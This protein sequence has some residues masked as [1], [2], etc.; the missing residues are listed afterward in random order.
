MAAVIGGLFVL[1]N[2]TILW[3]IIGRSR[4]AER[5][6]EAVRNHL[7]WGLVLGAAAAALVLLSF[8][9]DSP[10]PLLLL[11]LGAV[12][13]FVITWVR[14]FA[15]LM[16]QPDSAF[17]GRYDKPIWA[18]LLIVLPPVGVVAFWSYRRAH[19]V[20]RK[21]AGSVEWS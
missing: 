13:L 14:D 20:E 10:A 8:A 3:A 7:G 15:Y 21:P 16:T 11:L 19:E 6:A 12:V 17:P 9:A 1:V 18:F 2:A 5:F 4:A